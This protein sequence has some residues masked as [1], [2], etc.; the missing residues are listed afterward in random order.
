M[1]LADVEVFE[2]AF[3]L[4]RSCPALNEIRT[5]GEL[6]ELVIE[7]KHGA[8]LNAHRIILAA[9]IPPPDARCP[10][11]QWT[12]LAGMKEPRTYFALLTS[13]DAVFALGNDASFLLI[14][15]TLTAFLLLSLALACHSMSFSA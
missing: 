7:V 13:T 11:G 2:D 10:R 5:S 9:R 8:I 6:K 4:A 14:C 1:A 12:D 15:S 3:P